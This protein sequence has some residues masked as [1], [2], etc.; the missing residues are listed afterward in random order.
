MADNSL[1]QIQHIVVLMLENR[2]FDNA[3]GWLYDPANPAPFNR[4]PPANFEGLYGKQL[5]NPKPDS[6]PVP[7]GKG[8]VLTD[9][10]PDPG[11]PYED[12]YCQIYGQKSAPVPIPSPPGLPCNMQGFVYNY[13][14]QKDVIAQK[15][16]PGIIMNCFTP[17]SLPVLSSLA[18]YYGVC[19]RWFSSIPS[20]TLCNRS[21]VHAGTSSGY[22]NN[23]G[24]NGI[25]FT[26]DTPTIFDLL[27]TGKQKLE[28]L[29]R[30]L[31]HHQPG[32]ADAGTGV[33]VLPH[34]PARPLWQRE[35]FHRR[36]SAARRS[37]QLFLHRA[38]LYRFSGVGSGERHAPGVKLVSARW[39]FQCRGR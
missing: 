1:E 7:V 35:G 5:G 15:I 30:Q 21:F 28:N 23:G 16:D 22:V 6:T 29:L 8:N 31:A 18:Y 3:L 20:Q 26:N 2:S 14:A 38:D 34:R 25:L 4:V 10:N 32:A 13:A 12:V 37:A 33:E 17:A 36:R 39:R 11:E 27:E 19:D 24:S 9:P